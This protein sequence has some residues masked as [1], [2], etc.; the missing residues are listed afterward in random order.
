MA[1]KLCNQEIFNL[2]ASKYDLVKL[3]A[4]TDWDRDSNILIYDEDIYDVKEDKWIRVP[5]PPLKQNIYAGALVN[6][7]FFQFTD[8][9]TGII[10]RLRTS[11][12]A[13]EWRLDNIYCNLSRN[14]DMAQAEKSLSI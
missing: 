3:M 5:A 11:Y 9:E 10:L 1:W 2:L 6:L 7:Q 13:K 4:S 12:L 14:D 8:D